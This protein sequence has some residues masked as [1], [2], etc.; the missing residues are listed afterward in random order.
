VD[1]LTDKDDRSSKSVIDASFSFLHGDR[2]RVIRCM[3]RFYQAV[4]PCSACNS[5]EIEIMVALA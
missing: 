2:I 5:Y 4:I 1:I 3:K